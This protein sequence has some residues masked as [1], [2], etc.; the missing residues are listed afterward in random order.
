[1][2]K[3][4]RK[5]SKDQMEKLIVSIESDPDFLNSRPILVNRV[6]DK[7]IVYAGNQRVRAAKK[8]KWKTIPCIV[9]YNLSEDLMKKR[10][11]L[12]NKS[13]GEFDYDMLAN[14]YEIEMLI[15][16]GFELKDLGS[17]N[18]IIADKIDSKEQKDKNQQD[19]KNK[20]HLC[21]SCGYEF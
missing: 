9:E 6:D 1:M 3:N 18:E 21:P 10:I 14:D 20:S 19:T 7:L 8:L 13:F 17:L 16:S 11:V 15:E 4:P 12:D 5:I 2:E